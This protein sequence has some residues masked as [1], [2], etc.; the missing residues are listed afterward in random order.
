MLVFLNELYVS[1]SSS[2]QGDKPYSCSII[3]T[4]TRSNLLLDVLYNEHLFKASSE[5][6]KLPVD[7]NNG[8][9]TVYLWSD[10]PICPNNYEKL[11]LCNSSV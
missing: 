7:F 1:L 8:Y 11:K 4:S 9:W 6:I 3:P 2:N 10:S 5:E